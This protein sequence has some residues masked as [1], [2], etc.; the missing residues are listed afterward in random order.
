MGRTVADCGDNFVILNPICLTICIKFVSFCK[1]SAGAELSEEIINVQT[2]VDR[3]FPIS[4]IPLGDENATARRYRDASFNFLNYPNWE[5]GKAFKPHDQAK[6]KCQPPFWPADLFAITAQLL[7]RSGAY[8]RLANQI[9]TKPDSNKPDPKTPEDWEKFIDFTSENLGTGFGVS[10]S[11]RLLLRLIGA[12]WGHGA[13]FVSG[14]FKDD[15]VV[16]KEIVA[17]SNA[18]AAL[19]AIGFLDSRQ[20]QEVRHADLV[21][22]SQSILDKMV[23][24]L[25]F[26]TSRIDLETDRFVKFAPVTSEASKL[27]LDALCRLHNQYLDKSGETATHTHAQVIGEYSGQGSE[28]AGAH[29]LIIWANAYIQHHWDILR[30][31]N[32]PI[33]LSV[34]AQ[35]PAVEDYAWWRAALRLLIIAD[36]AG[37]GMGLS[38]KD[39]ER[40]KQTEKDEGKEFWKFPPQAGRD[41]RSLW[42][43]YELAHDAHLAARYQSTHKRLFPRTLT[44]CFEEELGSVLPKTRTPG[45]GCTIRSLSHNFAMLPPKGRVRARWARQSRPNERV[46]Y[47]ILVV[48]YPYQI[49]STHIAPEQVRADDDWGF[50]RVNHEWLY[51]IVD[52]TSK[53][54]RIAK[55]GTE[56]KECRAKF[57][58]FLASLIRD[59][60]L[61]TVNAVV[62]PEAALD[63]ET[64]DLVQRKLP[65]AFP[66]I[67]MLV[68]GLTTYKERGIRKPIEGNFVATYLRSETTEK[69]ECLAGLSSMLGQNTIDGGSIP[70]SCGPTPC[71]TGYP[72]TSCGGKGS[73]CPRAKC[74]LPNFRPARSLPR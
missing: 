54:V 48:P 10:G 9:R 42:G 65:G 38:D 19:K 52:E 32:R 11:H 13:L 23:D 69:A 70:S 36:E 3:A 7:E 1:G 55:T 21:K 72:R 74:C 6:L 49:K 37:K 18:E 44:R 15:K 33:G 29:S 50:F 53:V 58:A 66:S 71:P 24:E 45:T 8:Q 73:I 59:Q 2:L 39:G 41:C 67:E 5:S 60:P 28:I 46:A 31:S 35:E 20:N 40:E 30:R 57:W 27:A 68:C 61:D 43:Y 34:V 62:L 47:N 17:K 4:T 12:L 63:W 14:I 25:N 16:S 56:K 22:V 64:F 26:T 51:E